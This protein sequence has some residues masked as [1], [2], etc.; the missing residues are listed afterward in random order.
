[1]AFL[2]FISKTWR[3]AKDLTSEH[4]A[5]SVTLHLLMPCLSTPSPMACAFICT[6]SKEG[7][8]KEDLQRRWCWRPHHSARRTAERQ[9]PEGALTG[10]RRRLLQ[11]S[12]APTGWQQ[13]ARHEER[14]DFARANATSGLLLNISQCHYQAGVWHSR[15]VPLSPRVFVVATPALRRIRALLR[16]AWG[17]ENLERRA[18]TK[19]GT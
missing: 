15:P 1:M 19:T 8:S 5:L 13:K 3:M 2:R 14:P 17:R 11:T 16:Y 6:I 7:L 10:K 9:A 12:T 4:G 18:G